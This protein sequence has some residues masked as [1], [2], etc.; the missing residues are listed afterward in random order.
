MI[1]REAT[2][3]GE[4]SVLVNS[5]WYVEARSHGT[6]ALGG[7]AVLDDVGAEVVGFH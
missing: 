4:Y 1:L 7:A 2:I 5:G 6:D 3:F